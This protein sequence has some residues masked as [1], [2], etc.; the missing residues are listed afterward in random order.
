MTLTC[1]RWEM[2]GWCGGHWSRRRWDQRCSRELYPVL[3]G[4]DSAKQICRRQPDYLG[5]RGPLA[6]ISQ[7]VFVVFVWTVVALK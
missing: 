5:D 4:Q 1:C 2:S 3:W 6:H 7:L